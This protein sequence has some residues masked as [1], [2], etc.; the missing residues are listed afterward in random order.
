MSAAIDFFK[1]ALEN[2]QAEVLHSTTFLSAKRCSTNKGYWKA[3]FAGLK[4]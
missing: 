3:Q 1:W 4:G 2:G